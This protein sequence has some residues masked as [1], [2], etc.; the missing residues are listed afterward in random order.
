TVEFRLIGVRMD[1][2]I[3]KFV[4]AAESNASV[5]SISVMAL[6]VATRF[7]LFVPVT[8]WVFVES[9]TRV[10][11]RVVPAEITWPAVVAPRVKVTVQVE[12]PPVQ[13]VPL[14]ETEVEALFCEPAE[15]T[16]NPPEVAVR[17][18]TPPL[19]VAVMPV[20]NDA[21]AIAVAM[22]EDE[23]PEFTEADVTV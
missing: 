13:A 20:G 19:A 18:T 11:L 15:E 8:V 23:L 6:I 2:G 5:K 14:P 22:V 4:V 12:V 1:V 3:D 16:T 7:T 21:A 17:V 9:T 10:Q